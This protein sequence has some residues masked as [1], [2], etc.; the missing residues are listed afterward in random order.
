MYGDD[1]LARAVVAARP[2]ARLVRARRLRAP[3]LSSPLGRRG[4]KCAAVPEKLRS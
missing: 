1:T 2:R 3:V 4:R